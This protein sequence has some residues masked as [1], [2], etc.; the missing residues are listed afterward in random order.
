M[1]SKLSILPSGLLA[2]YLSIPFFRPILIAHHA[3]LP[4]YVL[5]GLAF[6]VLLINAK[7]AIKLSNPKQTILLLSYAIVSIIVSF[8]EITEPQLDYIGLLC[9]LPISYFLGLWQGK[10]GATHS[11]FRTMALGFLPVVLYVIYQLSKNSFSYNT[12]Y[13]WSNAAYK[14]DYLT[15]SLFAVILMIYFFFKGRNFIEKYGLS[16]FFLG[17][18]T[19]S[20]AR[21]SIIFSALAMTYILFHSAKKSPLKLTLGLLTS[22]VLMVI[23][24]LFDKSWLTDR[25]DLVS[26]SLFRI[27]NMFGNDSSIKGRQVLIQKSS[28]VISEHFFT[29]VGAGGAGSALHSNYPHNLL[30]EAFIDGGVFAALPLLIF[31][32]ISIYQLIRS[33]HEDKPWLMLLVLYLLGGFLKSFSIYE[34]RILFFFIGYALTLK[35]EQPSIPSRLLL[36]PLKNEPLIQRYSRL[37]QSISGK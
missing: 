25:S 7:K 14:I 3:I 29:G 26:Y 20:G 36:T 15:M 35:P 21:Y 1:T 17:F 10:Y 13:H 22:L 4:V 5:F 37:G 28:E 34:A 18:I 31:L 6:L 32:F 30:L 8:F 19:M 23:V 27:E 12:Y 33:K 24:L 16:L 11:F 9:F 2:I